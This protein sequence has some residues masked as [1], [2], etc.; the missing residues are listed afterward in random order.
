[1]HSP[2]VDHWD[3]GVPVVVQPGHKVHRR[4]HHLLLLVLAH[5]QLLHQLLLF[6]HLPHLLV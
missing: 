5:R 3:R 6:L 2:M 1:M 4:P